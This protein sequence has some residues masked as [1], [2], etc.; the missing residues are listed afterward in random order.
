MAYKLN[1]II[2]LLIS[3]YCCIGGCE[4]PPAKPAEQLLPPLLLQLVSLCWGQSLKSPRLQGLLG[5]AAH[6][7]LIFVPVLDETQASLCLHHRAGEMGSSR[8]RRPAEVSHCQ[9]M[10]GFGLWIEMKR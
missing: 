3:N 10:T 8:P 7:R 5:I 9:E 4:A 2:L 6:S 1:I